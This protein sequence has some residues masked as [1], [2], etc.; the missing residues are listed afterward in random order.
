[1]EET[2]LWQNTKRF[3]VKVSLRTVVRWNGERSHCRYS[4]HVYTLICC[5]VWV[6]VMGGGGRGEGV[7]T[8]LK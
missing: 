4:V 8:E 7:R 5:Y 6:T 2:L 1:M 3:N